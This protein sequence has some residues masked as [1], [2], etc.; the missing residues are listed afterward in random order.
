MNRGRSRGIRS[1][2]TGGR[3]GGGVKQPAVDENNPIVK[4]FRK[5]ADELNEK[6]DRYERI[7]KLS[8]DITIESKRLIF[9]LHTID[10]RKTNNQ[11][12]LDD[13]L[14]RLKNLCSTHFAAIASELATLDQ[15][16]YGRAY[17]AGLQEFIEAFTFYDYI[18]NGQVKDWKALQEILTFDAVVAPEK[19]G[20]EAAGGTDAVDGAVGGK[21][22]GDTAD[23]EGI[24]A[25]VMEQEKIVTDEAAG[26]DVAPSKG[27]KIVCLVQPVEFMLGLADLSGEIMRK[28]I[29]SLGAGDIQACHDACGFIQKMFSGYDFL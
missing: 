1:D 27:E 10:N 9:L 28:C 21:T 8:R 2:R 24:V 7:V 3:Q 22:T 14:V 4:S 6:H 26:G 13:A 11:Q 20:D 12:I 23:G 19:V 16:Q 17:S 5:Y 18:V 29:N 15:Y 25:P